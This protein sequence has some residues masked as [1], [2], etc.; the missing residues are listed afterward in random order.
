[1]KKRISILEALNK[2]PSLDEDFYDDMREEESVEEA[3][4]GSM[5]EEESNP[6]ES[7]LNESLSW[8]KFVKDLAK[9]ERKSILQTKEKRIDENS[10]QREYNRRYREDW[11]NSTRWTK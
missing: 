11:R 5:Y 9:R 1:M 7:F 8:E 6:K 2:I 3:G 10:P 4:C